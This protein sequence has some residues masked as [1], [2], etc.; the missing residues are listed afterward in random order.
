MASCWTKIS[1]C[2]YVYARR[3]PTRTWGR[4]ARRS[5]G[6]PRGVGQ[7]LTSA[8]HGTPVRGRYRPTHRTG[9]RE[10]ARA[11]VSSGRRRRLVLGTVGTASCT[12]LPRPW[13]TVRP[14]RTA[15]RAGP[16]GDAGTAARRVEG[17]AGGPCSNPLRNVR[18]WSRF[19]WPSWRHVRPGA[20][21][22][23]SWRTSLRRHATR[24][25][26]VPVGSTPRSRRAPPPLRRVS[27]R[28]RPRSTRPAR[29]ASHQGS[30]KC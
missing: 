21:S 25:S 18:P 9:L 24:S 27:G 8:G 15:P 7:G 14:V 5:A 16:A 23:F 13:R 26:S 20:T 2:V 3:A 11:V 17:R 4:P 6:G 29:T 30:K 10:G 19:G 22:R 28:W 1:T 12:G